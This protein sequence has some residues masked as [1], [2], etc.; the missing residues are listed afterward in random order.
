[1]ARNLSLI[2][3]QSA[4]GLPETAMTLRTIDLD[5]GMIAN[6]PALAAPAPGPNLE[7]I[8]CTL[9]VYMLTH[10]GRNVLF[11]KEHLIINLLT[12]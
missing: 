7:V 3:A 10:L 12:Q 5:L 8:M 11:G 2:A 6:N 1:M 4:S 9:M